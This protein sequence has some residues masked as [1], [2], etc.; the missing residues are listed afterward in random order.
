MPEA[1]RDRLIHIADLHFWSVTL[2]PLRLMGKRALGE[3]NVVL[4]RRHEFPMDR[5][6]QY[7]EAVNATGIRHLLFTGDFTST[8]LDAEYRM[9]HAFMER[10][11]EAGL[12]TAAIPGNH[13]VYTHIAARQRV[14]YRHLSAWAGSDNLPRLWRLPGGTSVVL[15]PTV[16]PNWITSKGRIDEATIEATRRLIEQSDGLVVV[17]AHYPLLAETPNYR[18]SP[19]RRL[20]NADVFRR[21]L[22]G[23][24]RPILYVSGHVHR[25]SFV[26][27][28]DFA[29]LRHLTT[30]TFFGR[31]P[32]QRRDG[33]FSEI[34]TLED[35]CFVI[36]HFHH[37][38]WRSETVEAGLLS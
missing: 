21:M 28:A 19:G 27:D 30:G 7:L 37:E 12:E 4:R 18:M 14:F 25:F 1:P 36:N 33:E 5:A 35:D 6:A 32:A 23:C 3:L 24:S 15:V 34:H 16:C 8:A 38:S 10:V 29:N 17:A 22:G 11:S 26:R 20:R 13:D 2:N 31:N 9:A